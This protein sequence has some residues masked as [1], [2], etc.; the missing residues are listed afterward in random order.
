[1]R[2]GYSEVDLVAMLP[3]L[4]WRDDPH[5]PNTKAVPTWQVAGAVLH[6]LSGDAD[7]LASPP[8]SILPRPAKLE[9]V[10]M[11]LKSQGLDTGKA[12]STLD[13]FISAVRQL[14]LNLPPCDE[15]TIVRAT[16]CLEAETFESWNRRHGGALGRLRQSDALNVTTHM[17]I[18]KLTTQEAGKQVLGPWGDLV[19]AIGNY[20]MPPSRVVDEPLDVYVSDWMEAVEVA[21]HHRNR[22]P[23][24]ARLMCE[25]YTIAM[26]PAKLRNTVL[27]PIDAQLD[28]QARRLYADK[29]T[30]EECIESRFDVLLKHLPALRSVL[31]PAAGKQAHGLA[32]HLANKLCEGVVDLVSLD[33]YEELE[34]L[35]GTWLPGVQA[36]VTLATPSARV[37]WLVRRATAMKEA[38]KLLPSDGGAS[39]SSKSTSLLSKVQAHSMVDICKSS[40]FLTLVSDIQPY[41]DQISAGMTGDDA[42]DAVFNVLRRCFKSDQEHRPITAVVQWLVSD[43]Q[44]LPYHEVFTKL[45]WVR[46]NMVKYLGRGIGSDSEWMPLERSEGYVVL[47]AVKSRMDSGY[48][49]KINYYNEVYLRLRSYIN[50]EAE[51]E[52]DPELLWQDTDAMRRRLPSCNKLFEL[53]GYGGPGQDNSFASI[54]NLAISYIDNAPTGLK[55]IHQA[56]VAHAMPLLL[57]DVGSTW[58]ETMAGDPNMTFFRSFVN[59]TLHASHL[60]AMATSQAAASHVQLVNSAYPGF[61]KQIAETAQASTPVM[62]NTGLVNKYVPKPQT[63]TN[64]RP[65]AAVS[66]PSQQPSTSG[67]SF[68]AAA[69]AKHPIIPEWAAN[70][71]KKGQMHPDGW[72]GLSANLVEENNVTVSLQL[73]EKKITFVKSELAK[74]LKCKIGDKCW[75]VGCTMHPSPKNQV[76]CRFKGQPG[77]KQGGAAH[78]FPPGF[79]AKV[80]VP[81]FRL[82]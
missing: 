54:V 35:V 71:D 10:L 49:S 13:A 39:G 58:K 33:L 6:G 62:P 68:S 80:Q 25:W 67:V 52:M 77:H 27:D 50:S 28:L 38:P 36:E 72:V 45:V 1:M 51:T 5:I 48:Y 24:V 66:A 78:T 41:L 14:S 3:T 42:G 65:I 22:L 21:T 47:Q 63:T 76:F 53:Y 59:P 29:Q 69:T 82:P 73:P 12:Y 2:V 75:A 19:L 9:S 64:K 15:L 37:A 11:Y 20:V 31:L 18:G 43:V 26:W 46:D 55:K 17:R 23:L 74:E 79:S 7:I 34:E 81:P 70:L 57:D 60:Q 4:D 40:Q 30:R 56:K 61:L 8:F 16:D 44:A 32:Q